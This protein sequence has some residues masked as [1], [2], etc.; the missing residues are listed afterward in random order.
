MA[1][2]LVT[3]PTFYP[4]TVQE[5]KDRLRITSSDE[6]SVIIGFIAG[7]TQWAERILGWRLCT[8]TW[9]LE[10]NRFPT[11]IRIPYP[12]LQSITHIKY[13]DA[14]NI[15]Q[16]YSSSEYYVDSSSY[17]GN[18]EYVNS[19]PSHYDKPNAIEV[20][21]VCGF[22]DVADIPADILDAIYLRI[23]DLDQVR[24][25]VLIGQ[26][27]IYNNS[28]TSQDILNNHKLFNEPCI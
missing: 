6:D 16:T 2:T 3:R 1:L 28:V 23:A 9:K 19:W 15:Q 26:G 11:V 13:Y 8:Q 27:A 20:Q 25:N 22:D 14:D 17:P 12:P 10:L 4:M 7:A 24:Q 18:I 21:F 5:V